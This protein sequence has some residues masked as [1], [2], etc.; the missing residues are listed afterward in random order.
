[1]KGPQPL[2]GIGFKGPRGCTREAIALELLS[3][4]MNKPVNMFRPLVDEFCIQRSRSG[5]VWR[6]PSCSRLGGG[7]NPKV[8]EERWR[9]INNMN[10]SEDE[11]Q[12][13][14][15]WTKWTNR[16]RFQPEVGP[17][18][19]EAEAR[20]TGATCLRDKVLASLRWKTC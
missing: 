9:T 8:A 20:V 14:S 5:S 17:E 11:F 6:I 18:M 19:N 15:S 2:V 1:M 13:A 7:T 10:I 3:S 4:I 12:S 16:S